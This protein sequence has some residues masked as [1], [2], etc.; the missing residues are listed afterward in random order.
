MNCGTADFPD[1][2]DSVNMTKKGPK[3]KSFSRVALRKKKVVV[4]GN[5]WRII[6]WDA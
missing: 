4:C 3:W 5:C 2:T 1:M 6:T